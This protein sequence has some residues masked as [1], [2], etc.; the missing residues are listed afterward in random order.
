MG[1]YLVLSLLRVK[2]RNIDQLSK[3][4]RAN[5]LAAVYTTDDFA[6]ETVTAR[7]IGRVIRNY[8]K[9]ANIRSRVAFE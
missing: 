5:F 9:N 6:K 3:Q 1:E 8:P 7:D 4:G 2:E